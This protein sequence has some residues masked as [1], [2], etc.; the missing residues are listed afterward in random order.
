MKAFDY[1]IQ[2]PLGMHARPAGLLA[3]QAKS[4][5]SVC[6]IEF[7]GKR[8]EL[9]RLLAVMGLGIVCGSPVTVTADGED[10]DYAIGQLREFFEANF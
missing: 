3:K 9:T 1:T 6:A 8:A 2:A 7:D 4:Y 5:Q 10:E